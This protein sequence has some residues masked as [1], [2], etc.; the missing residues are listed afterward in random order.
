MVEK[1]EIEERVNRVLDKLYSNDFYIIEISA[2]EETIAH[3][4]AC[5]L[6]SEFPELDVDFEYNRRIDR[7]KRLPWK[8]VDKLN[9]SGEEEMVLPDIVVHKRGKQEGNLLVIETKKST[10]PDSGEDDKRKLKAFISNEKYK[11]KYGLFI[12]ISDGKYCER[13]KTTYEWIINEEL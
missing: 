7:V 11:Y 13:K 4:L 6:A 3:K 1:E 2:N 9:G 8:N 12:R 10:N 5:Y